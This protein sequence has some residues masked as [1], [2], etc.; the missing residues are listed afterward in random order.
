MKKS[1]LRA[2]AVAAGLTLAGL[3]ACG[4]AP[5]AVEPVERAPVAVT[6]TEAWNADADRTFAARIEA[7]RQADVATRTSGTLR[8]IPV[9]VGDRV[10]AGQVVAVVDGEDV[11]ARIQGAEA[12]VA[13]AEQTHG[14]VSRLAAQGAA[15]PQELDQ[16]VAALQAARAALAEARA[17]A[18]YVE[19]TAPFAGVV[20][21][22]LADPGD[23][24]VPGRPVLRIQGAGPSL[25]VADLPAD[26]Q[27][28]VSPGLT[29]SVQGEGR[30]AGA[31]VTRVVPALDPVSRRFRVE[32][33]IE[34][35]AP[36]R[37][38]AVVRLA[39]AG[40]GGGSRWVP[41]DAV[42]RRGQ[43]TGVFSVEADTLRLRWLRLGRRADDAVEILAGPQGALTVVRRPDA[44]LVDG[45]PVSGV[46]REE[47]R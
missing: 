27:G 28:L 25:V 47:A 18:G 7:S 32:A 26:A 20:A 1:T 14:R 23:L 41:E 16:A 15:S 24:A 17:Q 6:V 44:G 31:S 43:L 34:G 35:E 22:R 36:W 8:S 21:A 12:Q 33:R 38:G 46:T 5:E 11:S 37:P 42:V 2:G 4:G 45:Q 40:A 39:L 29:V 30:T 19:V 10:Q 9:D 3:Q 13:L